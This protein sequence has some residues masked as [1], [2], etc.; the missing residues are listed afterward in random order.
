[1]KQF[2]YRKENRV[3]EMK[4]ARNTFCFQRESIGFENALCI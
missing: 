1:M 3:G 4:S 2:F